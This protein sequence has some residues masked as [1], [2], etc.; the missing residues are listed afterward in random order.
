[1]EDRTCGSGTQESS[2]RDKSDLVANGEPKR[3]VF[4]TSVWSVTTTLPNK[5]QPLNRSISCNWSP[6]T[7]RREQKKGAGGGAHPITCRSCR[8]NPV[9]SA[10]PAPR[11]SPVRK[12]GTC[13]TKKSTHKKQDKKAF[14]SFVCG[15]RAVY[16]LDHY[17]TISELY[18]KRLSS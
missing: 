17:T 7:V 12:N 10:N 9:K 5:I 1:M 18:R 11:D 8:V 4:A 14:V 6:F 13:D 15:H 3:G 16:F 2:P